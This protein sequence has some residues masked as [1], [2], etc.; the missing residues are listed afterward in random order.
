MRAGHDRAAGHR[1]ARATF[2]H[3]VR[4]IG[5]SAGYIADHWYG[6]SHILLNLDGEM[7]WELEDGRKF[8]LNQKAVQYQSIL[9]FRDIKTE[10]RSGP[11]KCG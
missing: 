4:M 1:L 7:P 6:K 10:C 5:Y 2:G 11:E 8:I 9:V 3:C